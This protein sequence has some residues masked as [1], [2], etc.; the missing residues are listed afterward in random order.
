MLAKSIALRPDIDNHKIILVTDRVDLDD[1][2]YHT[3]RHCEKDLVQAKTGN[4]LLEL[5]GGQQER[6]VTTVIDKFEAS[7]KKKDFKNEDKNIFVLVDESHRSQYGEIHALMRKVLPNACFVGVT[8]TPVIKKQKNTIQKFGGLIDTYTI[9]QAVRDK[10]VVPLLYEGR[11]VQLYVDRD[12]ID[13]WFEKV[14]TNI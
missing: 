7:L 1:Q 11:D 12:A 8:G 10:A 5:I 14:T 2:I 3:F 13:Q 6:I 9:D 4:H